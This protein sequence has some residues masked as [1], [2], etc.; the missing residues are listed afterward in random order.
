MDVESSAGRREEQVAVRTTI[1][2][3]R[4]PG[5]GRGHGAIPR[6]IEVLIKKAAVDDDFRKALLE[7]RAG[8]AQLIQLELG[9][10]EVMMINSAPIEQLESI[11]RHVQVPDHERR[12]FLGKV[13]TAML[14]VLGA[15]VLGCDRST[16]AT[17][18]IRPDRPKS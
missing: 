6:G 17:K 10:S 16:P 15:S 12:A 8:A 3:G 11:I 1:V 18:G 2:G 9:E 4:P 7:R 13:A 14:A 5:S